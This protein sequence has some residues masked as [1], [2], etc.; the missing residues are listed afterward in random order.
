MPFDVVY[1][2][3]CTCKRGDRLESIPFQLK[4]KKNGP[5]GEIGE[6]A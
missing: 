5:V 1:V 6:H 4:K 2:C 3:V